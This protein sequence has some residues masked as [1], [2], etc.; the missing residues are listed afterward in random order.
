MRKYSEEVKKFIAENVKG[1]TTRDLVAL[2]NA[3]FS[4]DF[5]EAK[6][7]TYKAN[8]NLKSGTKGGMPAGRP[9]KLY[10]DE[11]KEFIKENYIGVGP[12]EMAARLNAEFGTSYTHSQM[13]SWYN[14]H[15]LNSSVTGYFPKGHIPANKGKK[16]ISYEGMKATQ[17]KKGN[18][19][20]NWVSIGT[21]RI[22]RD[23]YTEIK[24]ADGR[25][26]KNWKAKHILLW[27]A[28]HGPVPQGHVVIFGDGNKRNFDPDNLLLV[29]RAQLARLNQRGLIQNNADLTRTGIIIADLYSKIGERKRSGRCSRKKGIL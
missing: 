15:K 19:P 29:S 23:G 20:A 10:P 22:N 28:A 4:L 7:K 24:I 17:F 6:M 18:R 8:N 11:V 25:L 12:K 5:T 1:M 2:V 21:E 13:K 26:N 27:E 14:N 3:E 16:G 9:S